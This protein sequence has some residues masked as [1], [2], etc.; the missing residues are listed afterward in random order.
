MARLVALTVAAALCALLAVAAGGGRPITQAG[1]R[2]DGAMAPLF[3]GAAAGPGRSEGAG[4]PLGGGEVRRRAQTASAVRGYIVVFAADAAPEDEETVMDVLV[5]GGGGAAGG[6]GSGVSVAGVGGTVGG[7]GASTAPA[8]APTVKHRLPALRAV[9]GDFSETAVDAAR[10]H[11]AVAYVEVDQ[12]VELMGV[13]QQLPAAFNLQGDSD[14]NNDGGGADASSPRARRSLQQRAAVDT[15]RWNL[16]RIDQRWLPL[17]GVQSF[18]HD[19]AGVDIYVLDSGVRHDHA[20]FGG[21]VT[22]TGGGGVGVSNVCASCDSEQASHGDCNGHGTH[23]AGVAAGAE[24][25][26]AKGASVVGVRVV[27]CNGKGLLSD[28]LAGIAHVRGLAAAAAAPAAGGRRAVINLSIGT[29]YSVAFNSALAACLDDGIV[30]VAAAGNSGVA[31]CSYSPASA[32]AALTVGASNVVDGHA[33]FSNNGP[34]VD[35]LAPG[36]DVRSAGVTSPLGTAH[37]TGTSMAAPHVAGA[38]AA[39]LQMHPTAPASLILS[40]LVCHATAGAIDAATVPDGTTSRL[41]FA[42]PGRDDGLPSTNVV[43]LL[44]AHCAPVVEAVPAPCAVS[45]WSPWS[46]CDAPCGA[47]AGAGTERRS[48]T[49]VAAA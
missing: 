31:A 35:V 22:A 11:Q 1:L 15:A 17:D 23:V 9:S 14:G 25:G 45:P 6:D 26:V 8:A 16:D 49:V 47:G 12:P 29:P 44:N 5:S 38:A 46:E 18:S 24:H 2:P 39:L 3:G 21:R 7:V 4:G 48:R 10:R 28:V 30:V 27:D 13:V 36:V 34:C 43:P 20:D 40:T 32:E 33:A 37:G 41:L 42:D 19:G